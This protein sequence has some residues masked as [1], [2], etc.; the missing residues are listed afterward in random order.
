MID[1]KQQ[2][3]AVTRRI[4]ARELP[5]G[6]ARE[7]IIAQTYDTGLDDLWDAVTNPER[8]PRWFLPVSGELRE[9][10]TYQLEGN[11]GGTVERCAKPSFAATWEFGGMV[12]WIEVEL[13][14]EGDGRTRFTLTHIAHVDDDLWAQYGPGAT[15]IGWDGALMGLYLHLSTGAANDPAAVAA[16]SATDE[17]RLFFSESSDRWCAAS[18]AAGTDEAEA[19]AA[20]DR[21]T[22]F[23][24]PE[25]GA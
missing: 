8:L 21:V 20:R 11:A 5:A 10:G 17:G 1:V 22:A 25:P 2:I 15:G 19:V 3:N 18:I 14:P 9:G 13:T 24:T 4:G 7:Q 23:Y 6:T 16:W 12:S